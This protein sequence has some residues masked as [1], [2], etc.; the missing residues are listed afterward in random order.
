MVVVT[1]VHVVVMPE[2]V[3]AFVAA[4]LDNH[5]NSVQ[6]PGNLRFDVL[7]SASQPDRFLLHE[8]YET[9]EAADAHKRT[10]HYLRWREAV[11]GMMAE[12][13]VGVPY[14]VL[15]PLDPADW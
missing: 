2:H 8:V 7:R 5:R 9:Q 13:R 15:A 4:T 1:A 11:A 14:T 12:P 3:E 10:A 6:E